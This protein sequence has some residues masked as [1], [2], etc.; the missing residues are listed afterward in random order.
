MDKNQRGDQR[1]C[2]DNQFAVTYLAFAMLLGRPYMLQP[3]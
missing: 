1:E 2:G 3:R